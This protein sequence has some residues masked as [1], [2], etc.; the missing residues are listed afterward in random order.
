MS[1]LNEF[2]YIFYNYDIDSKKKEKRIRKYNK[3]KWKLQNKLLK[4]ICN[5]CGAYNHLDQGYCGICKTSHLR[6][7][8]K[9]E[10]EQTIALFE[11]LIESKN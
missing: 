3:K 1:L 11:N 5:N 4:Y 2:G 6:K 10:R 7:A 8:T 9:D